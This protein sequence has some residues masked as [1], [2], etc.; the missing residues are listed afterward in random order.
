MW[1]TPPPRLKA[2]EPPQLLQTIHLAEPCEK[3]EV[4]VAG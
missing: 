4:E 2:G 3:K 1:S